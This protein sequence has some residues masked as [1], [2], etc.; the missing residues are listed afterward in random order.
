[1]GAVDTARLLKVGIH[2]GPC[3]AVGA[4]GRLDYF[5][6][7]IN[8]AARVNHESRGG[9]VV[10]TADVYQDPAVQEQLRQ[11]GRPLEQGEVQLRGVRA[12]VR[13]YRVGPS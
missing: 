12:P 6:T 5:G 9:E 13:L 8:V 11:T 4:N 2:E 10:L 7:T 1:V 3:I